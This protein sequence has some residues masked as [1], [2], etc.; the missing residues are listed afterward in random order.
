MNELNTLVA[1]SVEMVEALDR[2]TELAENLPRAAYTD[3]HFFQLE[4]ERVF[5]RNWTYVG[6]AGEIP[7][8]GDAIP[9]TLGAMPIVLVRQRDGTVRAF[10]N[11][12]RH[13]G[14]I[15]V[16]ERLKARS[17][18]VCPY[19]AWSYDLTGE[20]KRTPAYMGSDRH[21]SGPLDKSCMGLLEI[22]CDLWRDGV[23]VNL[24]GD[25][26]PLAEVYAPL[27]KRWSH[28]D[29]SLLRYGGSAR[30]RINANWK[31]AMENF[32][33][34]YHLP[35]VHPFLNSLSSR[36]NHYS[37]IEPEYQGQGSHYYNTVQAGHGDLPNFPDLPEYWRHRAEYPAILPN[38][39]FGMHPDHFLFFGV[40]PL[41]PSLTEEVFHFYF[42]GDAA[43]DARYAPLRERVI[44]NLQSINSEDI[45]IVE[46]MQRGRHSPG[47]IKGPFSPYQEA[48]LHQ[49]QLKIA[50]MLTAATAS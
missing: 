3:P 47:Y 17:A 33:E 18:L 7:D 5:G 10:H 50:K 13:R 6:A 28:H 36:D 31:L 9:L 40:L 46:N 1:R 42:V 25:A 19:H 32:Q 44:Q 39:M 23:F 35:S 21:D 4:L 22:R 20:L 38:M 29:L 15:L 8:A 34:G 41:T 14:T 43:L 24:S 30:L 27:E 2:P 45:G 26:K 49:F 16:E 12:C 37:V 48:T 11:V